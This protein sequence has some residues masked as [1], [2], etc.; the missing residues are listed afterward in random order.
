MLSRQKKE[1]L[2]QEL[3]L[4]NKIPHEIAR[5]KLELMTQREID[6][7][8]GGGRSGHISKIPE[9]LV[10]KFDSDRRIKYLERILLYVNELKITL[11]NEQKNI[12]YQRWEVDEAN[13]WEEVAE[14]VN[15]SVKGVYRKRDKI[16]ERYAK[17]KGEI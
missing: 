10:I 14:R 16:L 1:A 15:C 6:D 8:F 5:R 17:V 12:F 7:N 2:D 11:T 13:T 4:Y 3:F 9:E